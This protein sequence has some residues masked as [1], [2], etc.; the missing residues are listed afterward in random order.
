LSAE[1]AFLFLFQSNKSLPALIDTIKLEHR[2]RKVY[3]QKHLLSILVWAALL[4]FILSG[5]HASHAAAAD[6]HILWKVESE[7]NTVYILGS[8]HLMKPESYPLSSTFEDVFNKSDVLVLEAD[9]DSFSNPEVQTMMLGASFYQDGA[10]LQKNLTKETYNL[11]RAEASEMGL[12]IDNF[13]RFK[14]WA[15]A[16]SLLTLKL[17]QMGFDEQYGI[18][19]YFFRKA[20]EADKAVIGLETAEFQ[21]SL[22]ADMSDDEQDRMLRQMLN[23]LNVLEEDMAEM[24]KFWEVGDAENLGKVLLESFNGF[25]DLMEK[26][27]SERNNNWLHQIEAYLG[28]DKT[29]MIVVGAGH[30]L[31]DEGVIRLLEREGYNI[32]QK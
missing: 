11:A 20:K 23:D 2:M 10:S 16:V 13:D 31:G 19:N 9:L 28:Q 12:N 5:L 15:F 4:I 14:P 29:Y 32:S 26:M 17:K 1:P 24:L 25:P 21:L 22:F 8:I 6:K 27:I 30:L 7:V 3:Q 18:D